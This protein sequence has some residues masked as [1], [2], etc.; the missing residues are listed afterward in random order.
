VVT[1][2]TANWSKGRQPPSAVPHSL[3]KPGELSQWFSHD[4]SAINMVMSSSVVESRNA[5]PM[6]TSVV[7]DLAS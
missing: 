5:S 7:V 1:T 2:A 3:N 6:A 4:E